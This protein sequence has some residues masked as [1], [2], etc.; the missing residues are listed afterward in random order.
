MKKK[1][2]T[3]KVSGDPRKRT[4]VAAANES[5]SKELKAIRLMDEFADELSAPFLEGIYEKIVKAHGQPF[6]DEHIPNIKRFTRYMMGMAVM[7]A[8]AGHYGNAS[9]NVEMLANSVGISNDIRDQVIA[10]MIKADM[11][12]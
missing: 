12:S 2:T 7:L 4:M 10:A 6:P 5:A 1:K 8:K 9:L 3:Y 11:V